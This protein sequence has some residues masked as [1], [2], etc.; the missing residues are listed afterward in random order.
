MTTKK[1]PDGGRGR[2]DARTITEGE[3]K[4]AVTLNKKRRSIQTLENLDRNIR[5]PQ[6][7]S[8]QSSI[9]FSS[10]FATELN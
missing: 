7:G 10:S 9:Q 3:C 8:N 1:G 6:K 5:N 2:L 4:R